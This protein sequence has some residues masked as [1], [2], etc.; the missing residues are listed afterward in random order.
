MYVSE[1]LQRN[2]KKFFFSVF[3]I[4]KFWASR[5]RIQPLLFV[6][7]RIRILSYQQAKFCRHLESHKFVELAQSSLTTLDSDN[8]LSYPGY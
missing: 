6:Q 3:R 2:S 4:R 1:T 5:I 8:Y 7:I